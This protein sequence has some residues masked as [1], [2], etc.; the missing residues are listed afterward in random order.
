MFILL[1]LPRAVQSIW[2]YE[3]QHENAEE[4]ARPA[5]AMHDIFDLFIADLEDVGNRVNSPPQA[6]EVRGKGKE[7]I[8][9]CYQTGGSGI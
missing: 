6:R 8:A 3:R 9:A 2:H 7:A 1:K 4:I 5:G